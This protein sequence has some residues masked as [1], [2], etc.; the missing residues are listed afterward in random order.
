MKISSVLRIQGDI[1]L[2]WP[3]V[4][5]VSHTHSMLD[6]LQQFQTLWITFRSKKHRVTQRLAIEWCGHITRR[7]KTQLVFGAF[8]QGIGIYVL[9]VFLAQWFVLTHIFYQKGVKN[10]ELCSD[11]E[12]PN[13]LYDKAR[14][15]GHD[16]CSKL[17]HHRRSLHWKVGGRTPRDFP[18]EQAPLW[19]NHTPLKTN[20]NKW[21]HQIPISIKESLEVSPPTI[22]KNEKQSREAESEES[23]ESVER[24]YNRSK[25]YESREMLRVRR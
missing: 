12:T 13:Q 1:H 2:N 24:R 16:P 18:L 14:L 6:K 21:T 4:P 7:E 17:H 3:N 20:M 10:M 11:M 25:Y 22:W 23:I 9:Q 15:W 19:E 5:H 8:S